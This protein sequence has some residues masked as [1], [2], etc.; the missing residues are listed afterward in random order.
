VPDAGELAAA[1]VDE[2]PGADELAARTIVV[3]KVSSLPFSKS[4]VAS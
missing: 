4:S 2:G 3:A 1:V